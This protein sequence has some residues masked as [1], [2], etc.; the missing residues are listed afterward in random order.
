M[1]LVE[2]KIEYWKTKEAMDKKFEVQKRSSRNT[3]RQQDF[4]EVKKVLETA[5]FE[6]QQETVE[7]SY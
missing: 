4:Q 6:S 3:S 1:Q 7:V 5:I 2:E